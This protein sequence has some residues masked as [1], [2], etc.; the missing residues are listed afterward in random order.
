[1]RT[2]NSVLLAGVAFGVLTSGMGDALAGGFAIREQSVYGQ[3][4]SF[5]GIAAGGA[6]SGMFWNPAVMTQFSGINFE[7]GLAGILPSAEHSFS[8]STLATAIPPLYGFGVSDSG[9]DALVPSL[10]VSYQLSERFWLGISVNAPFG[11]SV[12]FPTNWAGAGYGQNSSLK[13]YNASPSIAFK[14]NEWL[15][16][17]A[18]VQIQY[19]DVSYDGL[20]APLPPSKF[21]IG[22][23]G[24]GWGWTVGATLTPTPTTTIGIGYRSAI[25][26]EI[27]GTLDVPPLPL[28]T[29]GSVSLTLKLPATLTVGL[30]QRIG[31]RFTL[32]AGFEWA[33]W[34][35]I[36]TPA[37]LSAGGT[38]MVLGTPLNLP[39]QY[40]DGFFY[41]IGGEYAIDPSLTVRAGFA[42][43]QSPITDRV[44]TPRLPDNDR[45]W[46]SVGA[47]Y[48]PAVFPGLSFDLA[49][50]FIDVDS[51]PI[52]I[53]ATS[54]NPWF[55]ASG[56]YIG[57]VN[58][59]VHILSL[60]ARFQ[61]NP[62]PPVLVTKG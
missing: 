56:T 54:G 20:L 50:S 40:S 27:D 10:Y 14:V 34:S 41:S 7:A 47:S 13:S 37:V 60:G 55:N 4:A 17:A 23:T 38:A 11:L 18:G 33:E 35:R 15:S 25:D 32:L 62:P 28:T 21:N 53:S 31:E 46:Y 6:L 24:W 51:T 52:N 57:T 5:A 12:A 48:K 9:R 36:G 42:Y 2:K 30:R 45:F 58:S 16:L 39:F 43:E 26:Q 49:Y 1:M 8:A 61:L 22:G 3:G 44:R 19:M 29:P 59:N